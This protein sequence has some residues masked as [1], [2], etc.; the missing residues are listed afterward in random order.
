MTRSDDTIGQGYA[1]D[2]PRNMTWLFAQLW[3]VPVNA[4]LY[5]M[6]MLLRTM[7]GMQQATSQG[8]EVMMGPHAFPV[9]PDI[10]GAS[11]T[12]VGDS[13][14]VISN[15]CKN[16]SMNKEDTELNDS[17]PKI[18]DQNQA[19]CNPNQQFP[20]PCLV[21]WRYKVLFIKRDFEHAFPEAE[22]LVPNDVTDITAW[23]IAEFIQQLGHCKIVVPRKWIEKRY[24]NPKKYWRLDCDENAGREV[25]DIDDACNRKEPIYLIG[26]PEDDKQFL[27]LYSQ[28]LASYS[29]QDPKY[30]ERKIEVLEQI[31][32]RIK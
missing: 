1:R 19:F 16:T 20:S 5:G 15:I 14:L 23:K 11:E 32:D 27:R 12:Q 7:L 29:R 21:L 8:V 26:L 22:D 30:E 3:M 2:E 6:N 18:I 13:R 25:E 10:K 31:R 17:G 9:E 28:Q 4:F 24:P